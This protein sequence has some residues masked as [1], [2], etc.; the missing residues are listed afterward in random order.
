MLHQKSMVLEKKPCLLHIQSIN[1][2]KAK[3]QGR[4]N[5]F[6]QKTEYRFYFCSA[7]LKAGNIIQFMSRSS[8]RTI[9][10]VVSRTTNELICDAIGGTGAQYANAQ[11]KI[12]TT[13]KGHYFFHNN[14][15]YLGIAN[16]KII[17]IPSLINNSP[18]V[19]GE[20]L[21]HDVL[22]STQAIYIESAYTPGYYL[23][24]NDDGS[25]ADAFTMKSKDRFSQFETY[26]VS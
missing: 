5:K 16:G 14:Y 12:I 19:Q 11:W 17:I 15:N 3:V 23:A 13:K 18:P 25:P 22:G 1:S 4:T 2:S 9:Q 26:I 20:F 10:I 8:Q 7:N 21:V 6:K 24:F